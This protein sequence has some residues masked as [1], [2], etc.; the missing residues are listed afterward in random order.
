MEFDSAL[1]TMLLGGLVSH[2]YARQF[3]IDHDVAQYFA[4]RA[5]TN[6]GNTKA[7][8]PIRYGMTVRAVESIPRLFDR[9]QLVRKVRRFP[10]LN[11]V[12]QLIIDIEASTLGCFFPFCSD[13]P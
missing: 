10:P 6:I 13:I 3:Q 4:R 7:L 1:E 8:P 2:G 12:D 9:V 5:R 11:G